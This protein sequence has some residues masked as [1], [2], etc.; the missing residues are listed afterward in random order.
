MCNLASITLLVWVGDGFKPER[1]H[2]Y[3]YSPSPMEC[4]Y[5]SPLATYNISPQGN[6][7]TAYN[8]S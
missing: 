8:S 5:P 1:E 4:H 2:A 3:S 7:V 6:L